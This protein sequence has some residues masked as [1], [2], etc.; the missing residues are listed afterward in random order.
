MIKE[1]AALKL[2]MLLVDTDVNDIPMIASDPYGNF[3]PGPAG[4]P[5]YV[6]ASGLVEGN[7]AAP[8][9]APVDVARIGTTFLNDIAHSAGPGAVGTPKTVYADFIAGGSLDP[10]ATGE[11]D[12]ELLD[13]HF[14]CG[15]GRGRR[16]GPRRR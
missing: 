5:Q 11:Y 9:A 14:I 13:L 1:Q 8:V 7:L 16:S 3:L 15:D 12:N 4:L 2:G 6:T 10:V